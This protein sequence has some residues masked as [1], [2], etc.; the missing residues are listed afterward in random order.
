MKITIEQFF[1]AVRANNNER[2]S[3]AGDR[4]TFTLQ[5]TG[6][7]VIFIPT[8]TGIPR[9]LTP[10]QISPYLVRFNQTA[11]TSPADYSEHRNKS[12]VLAILKI[13]IGQNAAQQ[14]SVP[15][16]TELEIDSTQEAKE[17]LSVMRMH[18]SRERSR[19]LVRAAKAVF[20]QTH[21][22]LFCEVC[23]FDFGKVYGAPDF[24]EAH[25]VVPLKGLTRSR[26]TKISDLAMVCANCHRM[27]HR[28][29]SWPSISEL[30]ATL[31]PRPAG[32]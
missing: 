22:H 10:E 26:V 11:S 24:I 1:E 5:S 19:E 7:V 23:G 15:I 29:R 6:D 30:K 4:A 20:L 27:L 9:R 17:G 2:L 13:I 18:L 25:H 31:L 16:G 3:T 21:G 8:S 32:K 12:Y 28:G 14:P